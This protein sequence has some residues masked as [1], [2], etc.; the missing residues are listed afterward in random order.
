MNIFSNYHITGMINVKINISLKQT[1]VINLNVQKN[2]VKMLNVK[3]ILLIQ[4]NNNFVNVSVNPILNIRNQL[5]FIKQN[6]KI[7]NAVKKQQQNLK[8]IEFHQIMSQ[9]L[10]KQMKIKNSK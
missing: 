4:K 10:V 3:N 7:I 6:F 8:I 9:E 2:I 1:I 5:L